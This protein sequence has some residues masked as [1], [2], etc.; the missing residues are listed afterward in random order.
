VAGCDDWPWPQ[1]RYD[2][3]AVIFTQFADPAM[4]DRLFTHVIDALSPGGLLVLQGYTPRQLEYK[5]GGPPERSHLYTADL[6]RAAFASLEEIE[7][8][9]YEAELSEGAR[10]RGTSALIGLV[11]RKPRG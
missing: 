7:L 1:G 6:L 5:T 10:H 4:R 9:E 3:V 8:R 2:L 11:A